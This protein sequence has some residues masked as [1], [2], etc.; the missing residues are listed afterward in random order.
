MAY[1]AK[2]LLPFWGRL[3]CDCVVGA[4][5]RAYAAARRLAPAAR[6]GKAARNTPVSDS[7]IRRELGVL[8]AA[9]NHA[10]AEGRLESA[11]VVSL[12]PS[13][14]PRER[15]L[16]REEAAALL[17]EIRR[18]P[19]AKHVARFLLIGL[20]TGTRP[21][22]ILRTRW[23]RAEADDAPWLDLD[24][25]IYHR[26]GANEAV[27]NKRRGAC[28][29]PGRLLAHLRR[30]ERRGGDFVVER[31]GKPVSDVGKALDGSAARA[32]IERLTPHTI[33][34]TAVSWFFQA[35]GSLEDAAAF[36]ATTAATLERVYNAHDAEYQA[37]QAAVAGRG[38]RR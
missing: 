12:P 36:F 16:R 28:R 20:Y 19:Q 30:W 22:T 5:C 18:T 2:Q 14:P 9:L 1:A 23:R 31:A 32:G 27:T 21:G 8:Q 26:A 17:R 38:G 15:W 29:L 13:A 35:G 34:H 7:T 4:N 37:P 11:P 3:T 33:K 10:V 6:G 24:R 25:G